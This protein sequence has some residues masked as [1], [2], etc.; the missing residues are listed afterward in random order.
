MGY[1]CDYNTLPY[2]QAV[3][4]PNGLIAH[5]YG[6]LEGRRHDAFMLSESGLQLK[7]R[8]LNAPNGDPYVLYGDSAYGLSRNILSPFRGVN[9]N[10]QEKEFNK[11]MSSVR[12]SVEWTFGKIV[13]YFAYL[14]F[15]KNQK[16]L[17]Q[18]IGKYYLVGALLT[19][20][21]TCLY[22]STTSTF[23]DL[24]PPSLET[25]LSNN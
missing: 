1:A 3:T 14:D 9:L 19:N 21:H 12:M 20:C 11:A 23:F 25:Y 13:Q 24:Q 5:L 8:P 16:I 6:P 15:K 17:L 2:M 4:M 22:G 7:L 10:S 18:P